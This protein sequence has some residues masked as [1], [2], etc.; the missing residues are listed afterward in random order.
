ML[1][2][3]GPAD[4]DGD[5]VSDRTDADDDNDGIA[6]TADVFARDTGQRADDGRCRWTYQ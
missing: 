5:D 4:A 2:G 3:V 6:D 1:G